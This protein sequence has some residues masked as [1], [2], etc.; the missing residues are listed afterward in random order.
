M[1]CKR[2]YKALSLWMLSVCLC[3]AQSG[4]MAEAIDALSHANFPVA[5]KAAR[6]E[7]RIHPKDP[8]ALE[9]L[10]IALDQQKQYR[11]SDSV[12]RSALSL[13][14]HSPSLLNNFGNHLIATGKEKEARTVFLQLLAINPAHV[15]GCLQLA[16]IAVHRRASAEAIAFLDRLPASERGR[17][18]V[19]TLR[20]EALAAKGDLRAARSQFIEAL[21]IAPENAAVLRDLGTVEMTL[22][23]FPEAA[24]TWKRYLNAVPVDDTA[25]REHAFAQSAIGEV[26]DAAL[27][28]L[29]SYVHNHPNDAMGHY[30]LGAAESATAPDKALTDLNRAIA[31]DSSLMAA[32]A[33]RGLLLFRQSK[34]N[35]ALG[36]FQAA[37]DRQPDNARALD[38]LGQTYTALNR[39]R[40]AV[41]VLKRAADITPNDSSVLLHLG[42]ALSKAGQQNESKEV[43]AKI[44]GLEA[45]GSI[46]SN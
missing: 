18:D 12:F 19:K 40:D 41:P 36:D 14:P 5:E 6:A 42:L 28:V 25:Q 34:P 4:K 2:V 16:Q 27:C 3:A 22:E 37:A 26:P 30:E 9:V 11:E 39:Y 45:K 29:Q 31:L 44:R 20:G 17:V 46:R 8:G 7:L 21:E 23:Q 35:E 24:Q 10:A 15:N 33:A 38:R 32:R 13:N 1:C 43:F